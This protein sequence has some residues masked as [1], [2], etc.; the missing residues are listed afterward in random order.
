MLFRLCF[1]RRVR[2][3]LR[4]ATPF[5]WVPWVSLACVLAFLASLTPTDF[6]AEHYRAYLAIS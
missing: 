4:R 5:L 3:T 2:P 6:Q 1:E